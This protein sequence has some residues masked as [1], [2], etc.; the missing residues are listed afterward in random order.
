MATILLS[1]AGAALG[2]SIGGSFLGLSMTAIG[3]FAGAMVGNA[4]DRRGASRQSISTPQQITGGGSETIETG[5]MNRFRMTS[6]GEG[7][8]IGQVFGRMRVAGQVI[9]SSEFEER[10]YT[11]TGTQTS[12]QTQGGTSTAQQ[13]GKGGAAGG[14]ASAQSVAPTTITTSNTT[15]NQV[16]AYSI[17]IAVALCE[18][19]ITSIGRVWAD[20]VEVPSADLNMRV[21]TGAEDQQP[22]PKIEAVEGAGMAP[23]YRGTA[24]VVFE[25]L[26][27]ADYGNRV[28]QFTFEVIRGATNALPTHAKDM[29][30]AIEGVA[31]MPGS[32]EFALATTPVHY[33]HGL[34]KRQSVNVNSPSYR[35]DMATS[36]KMLGEE[37]PNCRATSLVVSWFG[38]DL[39]C[40]NCDLKPKVEQSEFEG[41][42]LQWSVSGVTR[43]NADVI[44]YRDN[45]PIYG[46]TPSDNSVIEAIHAL[47]DAGQDVMFYP[48]ILMDQDEGNGLPNPYSDTGEQP[49]LPW[50]GRITCSVAPLRDGSPDGTGAAVSQVAAFFGS[51]AP[52]DFE[53]DGEE[54]IYSGPNEWSFRRFILHNASLCKAAGGV[55][56]F[57][58]GSEMRGLTQI[59]GPLHSFPA[60]EQ[61]IALAADVRAILGAGCKIGY[62]ADWSEYFGYT[63]QD[64]KGHH[65][66]HLDPLWADENIDFIGIDNYM[67]LSDWRETDEHLD[68]DWGSIYA[69]DYLKCNIQGGEGYDW[70]YHSDEARVAQIRTPITDGAH[71][72]PWIYR[73]KDLR[74]WWSNRHHNR[75]LG[76]RQEDPTPWV[77]Q[78]KP[79]WF[80]EYGC[81]AID[82]GT[83]QPNKFLDPKSSESQ[84][85]H[86]SNGQRDELM[87]MQYIRAVTDYWD[88]SAHNPTSPVYGGPMVAMDRA[89]AWSWDARP[90][91]HFPNRADL[92]SDGENY[93]RGH[94]INGRST[95][96]SLS[97]VVAE[98]CLAAG[99][100]RFDVRAL[101][102]VV[103]G[104]QLADIGDARAAIQPLMLRYGFDA[105]ERD[106]TLVFL[107]R[108]GRKDVDLPLECLVEH[109]EIEGRLELVR[110][111]DADL[112]GRVRASFVEADADFDVV[113]EETVLPDEDTHAV[114]STDL[115]LLMTRT[116][117]RQTLERWLSE[118]RVS[119][120]ALRFAL[121]L[122]KLGIRAGDVVRLAGG[123]GDTQYR[124][125]RVEQGASQIVEAVRIEPNVYAAAPLRDEVVSM[126]PFQPAVPV[127][128]YFLDL[129]LMTGHEVPYAP[130]IA[131][132]AEPWP[133][134]VAIYD[135]P[136]DA[137]Y[138]LNTYAAG[139]STIGVTQ[140]PL[141]AASA[142]VLDRGAPL[143]VKLAN[144]A[145]ESIARE[146][147]LAGG[148]LMAIGDGSATNWEL[149]QFQSAALVAPGEYELSLRLRGLHGTDG[150]MPDAWPIGSVIVAMNGVPN[151]IN[152]PFGQ[153]GAERHYRIG[154]AI[155]AYDDP[156]YEVRVQE[157]TGAGLRP[158]SPAH[159]RADVNGTDL[160]VAWV[161]RT[162]VNGD[163]WAY[164][165]VPLAEEQEQYQLRIMVGGL[166]Q[167]Q[168]TVSTPSWTYALSDRVADGATGVFEIRVAQI[169][170]RFGPGLEARLLVTP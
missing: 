128:P 90:Y 46:G 29:T 14:A 6:A 130:H 54:V 89:F 135:A 95:S 31:L 102:G 72:E 77:P 56:S 81:A 151:Q 18:G 107:M 78:S 147:L 45:R 111:S 116:E 136:I 104:Y 44:A 53:I 64:G 133:G 71:D 164:G 86:Y 153:L 16:Y 140:T 41:D 50:R 52:G 148:N 4:I 152:V 143:R 110:G 73:Y 92:W 161:R 139:R 166:V 88:E 134:S 37:L 65:F 131:V 91:P 132:T 137:D 113:V 129:P 120:E 99:E 11:A 96:R 24:Y 165:D 32:G 51:A 59:R 15:V 25:N 28:P 94:W 145:F 79:F 156:S 150:L 108:D 146:T 66:F 33:D 118:A 138:G 42:R 23:A 126:R 26:A 149:L 97:S 103:R 68:A 127:L 163:E 7:R 8:P 67:P 17:S 142:A 35:S 144:G 76:V 63:P 49:K 169:S 47:Q 21:Y 155:R 48:F 80:T 58:I 168:L 3:R 162:R 112:A 87:Q 141:F 13:G 109:P 19:E 10:I 157:F 57:C 105:V 74:N 100:T 93:W 62:A 69:L 75:I 84:I 125:D 124:V 123:Q 43:A 154:P 82:K 34:G 5:Q 12:T 106:G 159:L 22:D 117:A 40:A 30:Q 61:L 119:R 70:F 27:V 114:S 83:N 98:I 160:D 85:P 115:P 121:P 39:R 167:R 38:D 9:W 101:Y 170:D 158:L 1:T 55:D 60:V 122:S 36:V 2:S 20:G